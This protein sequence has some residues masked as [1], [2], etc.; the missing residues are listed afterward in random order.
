MLDVFRKA[1][2]SWVAKVLFALLV[3]SFSAWG[4]GDFVRSTAERTPAIVVGGIEVAPDQV[5]VEYKRELEQ[6]QRRLGG[7]L[8]DEQARRI[9]LMDRTIEQMVARLLL[10]RAAADMGLVADEAALR[11]MIAATPAFQNQQGRFDP[12]MYRQALAASGFTEQSYEALARS[13][14]IRSQLAGAISGGATAPAVM[15]QAV[16]RYRGERRVAAVLTVASDRM[17]AP[18]PPA[19]SV[20]EAYHQAQSANFMAPEYRA[21]TLLT[22]TPDRLAGD[23]TVSD[24]QVKEAFDQRQSDFQVPERRALRQILF[25][26][27]AAARK[28]ATLAVGGRDLD[29]IAK[30]A[31][32]KPLDVID[33]GTVEASALPP[34]LAG[35]VFALPLGGIS[36]PLH[37]GLGWHLFQVTAIQPAT[38][39][40]MD[41]VKPQLVAELKKEQAVD[42]LYEMANQIEDALGGGANIE[43]AGKRFNLPVTKIAAT[44]AHGLAPDGKPVADLPKS[45]KLLATLFQTDAGADSPLTELE[46]GG[47]F[48][49]RV[50]KVTPPALRPFD[51]VKDE[52]AKAWAAENRSTVARQQAE[53]V[54]GEIKAGKEMAA[55]AKAHKLEIK[56]SAPF[57]REQTPPELSPQLAAELFKADPGGLVSGDVATGTVVARLAK[58]LPADPAA[59]AETQRQVQA[60]MTQAM[61]SDLFD[62]YVA[63]LTAKYGVHINRTTLEASGD[64]P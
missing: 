18:P 55:V 11:R 15:A 2:Q 32:P 20:L 46:S 56:D 9:G 19:R 31:G 62:Q 16:A 42:K 6:L 49:V 61:G 43:E 25:Q 8:T 27:E 28:A 33:L 39:Q 34:D 60:Q 58:V 59:L 44:D 50:D 14:M 48:L 36:E 29:G 64:Q 51:T 47:Y 24:D 52:V 53:T 40:T 63:A 10:D 21:L 23:I 17:P 57:T 7:Q 26:D 5:M 38:G 13:D 30:S 1:S 4:V 54:L 41:Q 45:D 12:I 37:S 35:P 3:L 22:L